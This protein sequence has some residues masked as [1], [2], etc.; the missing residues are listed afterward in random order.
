MR[1]DTFLS[2]TAIFDRWPVEYGK[3]IQMLLAISFDPCRG[4]FAVE[5][6]FSEGVDLELIRPTERFAMEVKT[7]EGAYFTLN[8]KDTS[9][10]ETKSQN[11]GYTP[12][13]AV[14]RR[15]K[16][17]EWVI[18]NAQRLPTGSHTCDRLALD[19]IPELESLARTHFERAV[20]ELKD[21]VLSPPTGA[22][23]DFLGTV[24]KTE[25]RLRVDNG[26]EFVA[27]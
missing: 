15:W 10:L 27:R 4:G 25:S 9:G 6:H 26:R 20:A 12:A 17:A 7:T 19:S 1:F 5:N 11:D 16:L 22:P 3:I 13:V 21:R 2:L 14:L 23:L 18:G 8:E 24:L